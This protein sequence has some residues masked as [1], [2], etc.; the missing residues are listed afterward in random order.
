MVKKKQ[1][2][3]L[4]KS[5][6]IRAPKLQDYQAILYRNLKQHWNDSIH[7]CLSP[8]QMGKSYLIEM[9]LLDC[10][11]NYPNQT[12]IVVEPTLAQSRK[13][14]N[15][16]YNYISKT[17]AYKS[18][19]SQL[20][21][22]KFQNGSQILFKSN[23]QGEI[24]LR[25]YTISKF[26]VLIFDEGAYIDDSLFYAS[27]PLTNAKKA[28]ILVFSTPRWKSGFF[29]D[30]YNNPDIY[31]YNWSTFKNPFLTPEKYAMIKAT[32]PTQLFRADYLGEWMESTSD[33]FGNYEKIL[34]NIFDLTG[35]YTAGIDWGAGKNSDD[36]NSDFTAISILNNL[37]QQTLLKYQNNLDETQT[38]KWIVD[39]LQENKVKKAV[40]EKNSIGSVY[41]GLLKKEIVKRGLKCQ[42]I[43]LNNSN[44]KK[45]ELY[46]DL[47]VNVQ[48]ETIQLLPDN[49]LKM[50][51]AVLKMEKTK[52]GKIT[53]NAQKPYHDDC[54]D[55]TA[56]SLYGLK[57]G[58][59]VYSK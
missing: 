48:N 49:E 38:I 53:Y 22:I 4:I 17:P 47:I 8:R 36:N 3:R 29:Y 14:A 51:M 54:I 25:G 32:M 46:Q 9:I 57:T 44:E 42:I 23:E 18:Y 43:I 12:S 7:V 35:D 11:I 37:R 41:L 50:E 56:F 5:Q 28:P 39:I 6:Q 19:N 21:E 55:A 40:V 33:I 30:F 27:M 34:S 15:E 59:Y 20:L 2:Q 13:M 58:T 26:G 16:L 45:N 52:T 24:A 31:T 1:K 10:S